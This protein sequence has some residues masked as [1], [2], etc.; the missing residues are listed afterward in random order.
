[1]VRALSAIKRMVDKA[2]SGQAPEDN[3][4]EVADAQLV[5][6]TSPDF[7]EAM[8]ARLEGREPVFTGQP[9]PG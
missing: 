1:M 3:M 8:T 2:A 7:A 5:A 9:G 6:I 4:R